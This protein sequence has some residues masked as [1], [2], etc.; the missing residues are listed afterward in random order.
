MYYIIPTTWDSWYRRWFPL[1]WLAVHIKKGKGVSGWGFFYQ[2]TCKHYTGI[3]SI[4]SIS[5]VS[6]Y[7]K[8]QHE[9]EHLLIKYGAVFMFAWYNLGLY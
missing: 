1:L 7:I 2:D 6:G 9:S 8:N 5:K 3:I 4:S